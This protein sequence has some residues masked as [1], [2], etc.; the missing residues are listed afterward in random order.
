[1]YEGFVQKEPINRGII[2]RSRCVSLDSVSNEESMLQCSVI[3]HAT[4]H[5]KCNHHKALKTNNTKNLGC[6]IKLSERLFI[7]VLSIAKQCLFR[8]SQSGKSG[9]EIHSSS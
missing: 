4:M 8:I 1:M 5:M 2:I 7:D 6:K 3:V 9:I